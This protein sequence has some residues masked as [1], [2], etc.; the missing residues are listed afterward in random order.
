M[1]ED[2]AFFRLTKILEDATSYS[3]QNTATQVLWLP[4]TR[5]MKYKAKAAI[6]TFF[7][8]FGDALAAL[9]T[10][11]S[12]QFLAL[13]AKDFFA[14]NG[15]ISL[16]WMAAA[17]VV[18]RE[19]RAAGGPSAIDVVPV[20]GVPGEMMQ[21]RTVAVMRAIGTGG[22]ETDR[23]KRGSRRREVP[24]DAGRIVAHAP[25][26]EEPQ[27]G[28]VEGGRHGKIGDGEVEVMNGAA[29]HAAGTRGNGVGGGDVVSPSC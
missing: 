1:R 26:A 3:L 15:V 8:R 22:L 28:L 29:H 12:I 27:H 18:V 25:V 16:A 20:R 10:F 5:E 24:V 21:S 6:D 19:Y 23:A 14:W 13:P 9:T 4:T 11:V 17:I 2:L 7:V